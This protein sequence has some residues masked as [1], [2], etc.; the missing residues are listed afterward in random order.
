MPSVIF[1]LASVSADLRHQFTDVLRGAYIPMS[2]IHIGR[3]LIFTRFCCKW[4]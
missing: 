3:S 2:D 4:Y 1:F